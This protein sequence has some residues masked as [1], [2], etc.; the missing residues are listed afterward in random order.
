MMKPRIFVSTVSSELKTARQLVANVLTRLG[1]EPVFQEI[2]DLEAGDLRQ[3]LREKIDD[4][5]G[6]IQIV[7]R[8]YGAE[9]PKVDPDLGRVSYTQFEFLYARSKGKK[10]WLI[11]A[12]EGCTR[13]RQLD[14]LDRPGDPNHPD[15]NGYQAER[16]ELQEAWRS[17][18]KQDTHLFHAASSDLELE[19][20]V[21]RM[22]SELAELRKGFRRL[23]NTFLC[24]G[25]VVVGLLAWSLIGQKVLKKDIVDI[26]DKTSDVE[27]AV[28]KG[29]DQTQSEL[30][31]IQQTQ[32][33]IKANQT[34]TAKRIRGYLVQSSEQARDQE[35]EAANKVAQYDERERLKE[36]AEKSHQAR[37]SRIDDLVA[38]II[39]VE[40]RENVSDDYREMMRILTDENE[41][42]VEKAIAFSEKRRTARLDGVRARKQIE[43]ARNRADLEPDLKAA[44]LY[45]TRGQ[46][47]EARSLFTEI[48]KLEPDWPEPLETFAWFLYDQ[49]IQ[50][51]THG[52]LQAALA[53]AKLCFELAE[54]L[55]KIDGTQPNSQQVLSAS[56]LSMGNILSTRGQPGDADVA[57][58]YYARSLAIDERLLK[59]Y[60]DSA[61][62]ARAVAV[63]LGDFGDFL[64]RGRHLPNDAGRALDYY[65]RELEI[66]ERLLKQNPDSA[67]AARDV[68]VSFIR[69]GD[70][71]GK[72]NL[73]NI[74]ISRWGTTQRV[75]KKQ[76]V[77]TSKTRIPRGP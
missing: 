6:L 61:W 66:N 32:T 65:T 19:L 17:R 31:K 37:L 40:K 30:G 51:R 73:P 64:E 4:C 50:S 3:V 48:L 23:V 62:A 21:E 34:I 45:A 16:R 15:P 26:K 11:F 49:S 63:S 38:N 56:C 67:Q 53:D 77:C 44:S 54:R 22:K 35:L 20:R 24:L 29:F 41:N 1:Y 8:G 39:D 47:A 43:Q 46:T 9:P 18:W 70:F 72:R 13:D 71:T 74:Q 33:E 5:V 27:K 36:L 25:A 76:N 75:L 58:G 57:L 10:T 68:L 59:Q 12:N 2:F 14:Q 69:L 52:T 60:P 42:A 28:D 55:H 7:G